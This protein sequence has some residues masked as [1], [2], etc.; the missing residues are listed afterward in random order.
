MFSLEH[1]TIQET[2][3]TLKKIPELSFSDLCGDVT[4]SWL[5]DKLP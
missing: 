3:Q 1:Q 2:Q 5:N 4:N